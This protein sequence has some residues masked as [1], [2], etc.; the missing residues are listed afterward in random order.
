MDKN[1]LTT[2]TEKRSK[3]TDFEDIMRNLEKQTFKTDPR[4]KKLDTRGQGRPEW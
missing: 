2:D 3:L 4:G 1:L